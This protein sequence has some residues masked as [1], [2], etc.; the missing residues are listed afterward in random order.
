M[1]TDLLGKGAYR[2]T[3]GCPL[4]HISSYF[5]LDC[6][7]SPLGK[8]KY[9]SLTWTCKQF[10]LRSHTS[11]VWLFLWFINFCFR[12]ITCWEM[13]PTLTPL[14]TE[15]L[16]SSRRE[17]QL[18]LPPLL[19]PLP[20]P[21]G[22]APKERIKLSS[23]RREPGPLCC[24]PPA[25]CWDEVTCSCLGPGLTSPRHCGITISFSVTWLC[26]LS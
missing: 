23:C 12:C 10:T 9:L 16:W 17:W 11:M 26:F 6:S 1:G 24:L 25:T 5:H 13:L 18:P 20:Q 3:P 2:T 22:A 7:S 14:E 19:M 21:K 8:K 4:L 15:V